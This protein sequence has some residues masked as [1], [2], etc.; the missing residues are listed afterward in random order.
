MSWAAARP[1]TA[2]ARGLSSGWLC[3]QSLSRR[4]DTTASRVWLIGAYWS[5]STSARLMVAM[6]S[7]SGFLE[8]VFP[9]PDQYLLHHTIWCVVPPSLRALPLRLPH[10]DDIREARTP[11]RTVR[12]GCFRLTS[13]TAHTREHNK[14]E[15]A[16]KA[17]CRKRFRGW[18]IR[19]L[20]DR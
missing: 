5:L 12:K 16:G 3:T 15:K 1:S 6:V 17:S 8:G 14:R 19:H 20:D 7:L 18:E 4:I 13:R 2:S 11:R 9:P 10:E